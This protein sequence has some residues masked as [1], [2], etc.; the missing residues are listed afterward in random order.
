MASSC[1]RG[2]VESSAL[3]SAAFGPRLPWGASA[4]RK[5]KCA[6]Y[7]AC[8]P[9]SS[10]WSRWLRRR[11]PIR[12][13]RSLETV[14]LS[15]EPTLHR[16]CTTR[17]GRDRPLACGSTMCQP[18]TQCARGLPTAHPMRPR[19][20]C[21]RPTLPSARCSRTSIRE[22]RPSSR[23]TVK[24]G[25][26]SPK[27]HQLRS[28]RAELI[29]ADAHSGERQLHAACAKA[30]LAPNIAGTLAAEAHPILRVLDVPGSLSRTGSA[31]GAA[32]RD[33]GDFLFGDE[34]GRVP[35]VDVQIGQTVAPL[36]HDVGLVRTDDR[37]VFGDAD[38]GGDLTDELE[39]FCRDVCLRHRREQRLGR[40]VCSRHVI[41][42]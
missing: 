3:A 6:H 15:S 5:E 28:A 26:G 37:A 13:T 32:V 11:S 41:Q 27:T 24:T 39:I 40:L 42:R 22:S 7:F 10:R 34:A 31:P 19:T 25:R 14:S 8:L 38:R 23:T 17:A 12:S 9:C 33:A 16:A 20:M 1:H 36:R 21:C 29:A 30:S 35:V 4:W 18:R 2:E